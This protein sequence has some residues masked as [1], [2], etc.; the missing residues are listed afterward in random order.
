MCSGKAIRGLK[1]KEAALQIFRRV[2]VEETK[3]GGWGL[4]VAC[5][6]GSE[7]ACEAGAEGDRGSERRG[8]L[9]RYAGACVDWDLE[10]M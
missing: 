5:V 10:A 6:G 4:R 3:A 9:K 1:Q 7:K 8:K 2:Q